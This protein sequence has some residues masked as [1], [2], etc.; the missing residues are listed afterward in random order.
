M[1]FPG[2]LNYQRDFEEFF[3]CLLKFRVDNT[4]IS[5]YQGHTEVVGH[6][7]NTYNIER[8]RF[9]IR[10]EFSKNFLWWWADVTTHEYIIGYGTED[11]DRA[12]S[13]VDGHSP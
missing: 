10:I 5:N 2:F 13:V 1:F 3:D 6:Y 12:I 11:C 8:V 7:V 4:L 9:K